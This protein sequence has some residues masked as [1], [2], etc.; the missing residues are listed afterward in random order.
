MRRVTTFVTI[1]F[2]A[3]LGWLLLVAAQAADAP[4]QDTLWNEATL[5]FKPLPREAPAPHNPITEAKADL[6]ARLYFD[7]RLS[8]QGEVSCNSCHSLATFGV[9]NEPTS[10]GEGGQRGAR[11]SPTV[12]NAALHLAQF[13]D[14]RA[15]DVE[16]QAGMPVLNPVEMAIPS[17]GF[18]IDRLDAVPEYRDLFEEAFPE[19]TEPLTYYNVRRALAAFERTLLTPSPFDR[20]LE[21]DRDAISEQ[22]KRGM[23]RFLEL[24]CGSCHNGTTVGGHIFRKFGL[25]EPYWT[26]THSAKPDEGRFAQTGDVEDRYVFK[27]A[28]LRNVEKTYPYFHDG[29]V[30]KLDEAIRVMAR[31]Q[32]GQELG[33]S[34]SED[35]EAFLR[36]L[37]GEIPPAALERLNRL[38]LMR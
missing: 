34:E 23:H 31:L 16:E 19:A 10:E 28:A 32:V 4:D 26:H 17:A 38:G 5:Y 2:L 8:R 9:D 25:N 15:L 3:V 27:V 22:A 20:Y 12:L 37:T 14:G 6:G 7:T 24:G 33:P 35:I 21:G 13:W 11:N 36:S 30:A 18:L 1:F 29:S